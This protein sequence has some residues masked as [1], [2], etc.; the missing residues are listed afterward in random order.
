MFIERM[1]EKFKENEP[2]FTEEILASFP[3]FSRAQIF[4]YIKKAKENGEIEQFDRGIYYFPRKTF[5]GMLPLTADMVIEKKFLRKEKEIFGIYSGITLL[6][7]FSVTT[8][9]PAVVE[10]VSNNES[11]KYREIII[12]GRKFILRRSRFLI[13]QENVAIYRI[14]QLFN[15]FD[16]ETQ[17][18]AFSKTVLIDY[19][20][21]K[22]ISG[23]ELL[24]SALRFPPQTMQKLIGSGVL[25][26]I[27]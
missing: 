11:A 8:Q 24:K 9:I 26:D 10:I 6:N 19:M 7:A 4:R 15:D 13:D 25:D 23:R 17:L 21:A 20:K 27:A 2:I 12:K 16:E 14:L 3:E 5:F 1:K 22:G 18:N